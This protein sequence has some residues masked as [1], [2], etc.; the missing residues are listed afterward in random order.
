MIP[1]GAAQKRMILAALGLSSGEVVSTD[2]LIDA[3]ITERGIFRAPYTETLRR[4]FA[5]EEQGLAARG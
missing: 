4:A 3:V 2:R 1:V 5:L